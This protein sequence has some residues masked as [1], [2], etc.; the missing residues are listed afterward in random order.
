MRHETSFLRMKLFTS[1]AAL[2]LIG[3]TAWAQ[4]TP[5]PDPGSDASA[6]F[7]KRWTLTEMDGTKISATDPYLEFD[8]AQRRVS[9]SGGCNR[10]SGGFEVSR[11]TLKFSALMSTKRACLDAEK[12]EIETTFLTLLQTTTRFDVAGN[13]LRLYSDRAARLVL[14]SGQESGSA[15][16]T[17]LGGTSW[18]LV[19]FQ[20]SDE[21]TFTPDDKAKYTIT[22]GTDGRVAVRLDCNRGSGNWESP[23]ANQLVFGLLGLTRAMCPRGSLH[24][25]IAGDWTNIR[26]YT[27]KD[28]HLFLSL[29][30]DSGIYEFEPLAVAGDSTAPTRVTGTVTYLQRS[31]LRRNAL[32][33]V[34]LLDVSQVDAPAVTVA[35]QTIKPAGR[36]VPIAF[37]LVYEPK[38]VNARGSYTIQARIF[39]GN[40]LR[41]ASVASYPVITQGHPNEV[42]VV[43]KPVSR[44][45]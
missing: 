17:S 8:R 41:F 16:N 5:R 21:T 29:T 36:Q 33:E 35:K 2:L 44:R 23:S 37:D 45:R 39:E 12:Q 26:S 11:S 7:G 1:F 13:T 24:D 43:V 25:R 14:T 30:A 34:K 38:R 4:Q 20:S 3:S 6:L 15:S 40:N 22:F 42:N 28:G 19:K 31:A 27:V 32:V 18:Q 10:F 9:G